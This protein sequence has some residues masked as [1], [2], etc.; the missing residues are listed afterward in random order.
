[1]SIQIF[2]KK[3]ST[4]NKFPTQ[5]YLQTA[6]RVLQ[7]CNSNYDFAKYKWKLLSQIFFNIPPLSPSTVGLKI[8]KSTI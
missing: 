1:M 8:W 7:K 2:Q 5:I 4:Q 3:S 6:W